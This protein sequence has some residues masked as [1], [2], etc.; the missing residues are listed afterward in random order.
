MKESIKKTTDAANAVL[1]A[2]IEDIDLRIAALEGYA[3]ALGEM[4]LALD[5]VSDQHKPEKSE[6][7]HISEIHQQV[8]EV[9]T[10]LLGNT[11]VEIKNLKAKGKAFLAYTDTMPKRVSLRPEKKW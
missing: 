6:L 3:L 10:T 4:L 9:A 8:L 2:D 11:S 1:S 7:E 5:S